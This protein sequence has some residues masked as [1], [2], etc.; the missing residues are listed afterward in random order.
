MPSRNSIKQYLEGGYYHIYNRGVEKRT[1]FQDEQ[2]Y[3]VFLSYLR[4]YLL[5]KDS[6]A[7]AARLANPNISYKEREGV[8]KLLRLNNFFDEILL[9][10]FCL[11]RNHF[12][13]LIKQIKS[14]S[15]D[16]FMN[17]LI[18]RYVMYFNRKYKRVG[19]LFQDVYKAVLVESDAQLVYLTAYIHRNPLVYMPRT[20]GVP[21]RAWLL[22]KQPSSY[23]KY[24]GLQR[25]EW[26]RSEEIMPFFSKTKQA[27]NYADFVGETEDFSLVNK[28]L[29]DEDEDF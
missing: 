5:P 13:F 8:L 12:H 14:T 6:D 26:V 28:L 19:P 7:L 18:T 9:L 16:T 10:A 24:L 15:M 17:S 4:N 22:E 25:T 23:A 21:F 2:D 3:A 1:I 11:M 27:E 20:K 29:I